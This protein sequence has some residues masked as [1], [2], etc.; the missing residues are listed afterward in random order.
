MSR[1]HKETK[2]ERTHKFEMIRKMD[3]VGLIVL[4]KILEFRLETRL[5]ARNRKR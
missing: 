3:R 1:R 4:W 5:Q 2:M